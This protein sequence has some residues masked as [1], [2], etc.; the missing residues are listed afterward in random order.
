MG[1]FV[2]IMVMRPRLQN[3]ITEIDSL[4]ACTNSLLLPLIKPHLFFLLQPTFILGND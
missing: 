2:G 4:G 1:T 3:I